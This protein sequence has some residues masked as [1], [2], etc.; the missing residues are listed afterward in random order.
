MAVFAVKKPIIILQQVNIF[1]SLE[2]ESAICIP[3]SST[4]CW[5]AYE[6]V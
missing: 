4:V 6:P 1:G 3:I 2:E 5:V